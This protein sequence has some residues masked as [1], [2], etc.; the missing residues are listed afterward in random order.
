MTTKLKLKKKSNGYDVLVLAKHPMETGNRKDKKTG[1][2]IPKHYITSMNFAVNGK[3]IVE[4]SLSQGISTNPLIG[5]SLADLRSGDKVSV[6]W[7]DTNG[8]TESAEAAV[9]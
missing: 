9:K 5:V 8:G 6:T 4:A 3:D 1:K 7:V 2:L